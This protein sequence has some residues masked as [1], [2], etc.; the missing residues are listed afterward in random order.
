MNNR[1]KCFSLKVKL[2]LNIIR[3]LIFCIVVSIIAGYSYYNSGLKAV[4]TSGAATAKEILIPKG[5]S[6]R[7]I[8]KMLAEENIIRSSFV[9]EL[10]CKLN[11]KADKIKAGKYSLNNS[12]GVPDI[13]E[14]IVSG[15]AIEDT[16]RFTIPEGYNLSQIVEKLSS[17]GIVSAE[18][19]QAALSAEKYNYSFISQI[20]DRENKLEGYLFPDTYEIYRNA[21]AE[22]I[23]NKLLG[24][25]DKVFTEEYRNRAKELNMTIDEVVILASIIEREAKLDSERKIIS[26]VFHN[27][28]KKNMLLQSCATIQYLLGE[29]KEV[30][31]YEDLEIE[32]PY[33]TYKYAGLPPGP[34]A[35]PGLK[36]IEA[37]L[38]PENTDYL[39]FF[40]LGDGSHVFSKTYREHINAQ[41]KYKK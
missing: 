19:I 3:L 26:S 5:S 17:L 2:K 27:R 41:N 25:F 40:A 14:A 18:N 9:F 36:S 28:L 12:M 37:A 29:P 24:R 4:S 32:S 7:S 16:T 22:D 30:L 10:Y 35:S 6:V 34:I 21:K 33:N 23:I 11:N 39:Y 20:P 15:K 1:K 38:Y 8:S 13:V 31:T